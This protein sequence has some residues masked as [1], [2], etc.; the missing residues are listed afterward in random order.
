MLN[1]KIE[2]RDQKD[3]LNKIRE[4]G[5]TPA[6]FYGKGVE[7]TSITVPTI[8]FVKVW[9]EA[10]T[11]A[12]VNLTGV[13]E[14]REVIIQDWEIDPVTNK[15][16]HAD[17][18]VVE[19]GKVMEADIPLE[20]IGVSPAVKNLGG[21]LVKVLHEVRIEV[22][23]KDLPHNIEVDISVLENL[24][25]QIAIE[26]LKLPKG[27]T[28]LADPGEIVASISQASEEKESSGPA[29]ISEIEIEKK[30]KK[31]EETDVE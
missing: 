16:L 3:D 14:D 29:D 25:S 15:V 23:P 19:R 17:F 27:V 7:S 22:L 26:D 10:G 12:L 31:K 6:V 24:D 4:E 21:I 28:I 1:L 11:S 9:K 18:Y 2:K 20:F 5:K 13:G 8:D 30:G